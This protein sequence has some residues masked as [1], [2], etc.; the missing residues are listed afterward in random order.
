MKQFVK[1]SVVAAVGV[2]SL[3]V[4]CAKPDHRLT[5]VPIATAGDG[6]VGLPDLSED[7]QH[8]LK[9]PSG[10]LVL[11]EK[12]NR[13]GMKKNRVYRFRPYLCR[14]KEW[15]NVLW[16]EQ[17]LAD[18]RKQGDL[19]LFVADRGDD[20]FKYIVWVGLRSSNGLPPTSEDD[21]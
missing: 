21:R 14:Q 2:V 9:T 20:E 17:F 1:S 10:K 12:A 19:P 15:E 5:I 16:R 8:A 6:I 4:S 13:E 7:E 3:S 18:V 11:L